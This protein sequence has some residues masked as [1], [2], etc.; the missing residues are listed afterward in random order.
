MDVTHSVPQK[1]DISVTLSWYEA[2]KIY[3]T[4][5]W[6]T[7]KSHSYLPVADEL[8]AKIYVTMQRLLPST[9]DLPSDDAK[10]WLT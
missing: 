4:L 9:P 6:A 2:A 3:E 10:A 7:D 5:R 1:P 8:A